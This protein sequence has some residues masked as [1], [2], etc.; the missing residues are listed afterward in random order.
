MF[1]VTGAIA[2]VASMT[3]IGYWFGNLKVVKENFTL[4]LIGIVL[5]S[6]LPM[7]FMVIAEWRSAKQKRSQEPEARN[8][9][10]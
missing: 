5:I 8:Q 4:V 7:F 10:G 9:N 3:L 1:N 2:W 6:V